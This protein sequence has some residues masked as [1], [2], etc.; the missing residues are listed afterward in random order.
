MDR[1]HER[2]EGERRKQDVLQT[3]AARRESIVNRARRKLLERLLASGK[4]T[5]DDVYRSMTLPAGIDPR[6]LGSVPGPVARAGIIRCIGYGKSDRRE[7]HASI[8]SVW[9]LLDE[10]AARDWLAR[11]PDQPDHGPDLAGSPVLR[12]I[13]PNKGTSS[14]AA[15]PSLF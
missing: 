3:L 7:R 13:Q 1:N 11:H 6:C 4:A 8:L 5:A 10:S 15:Q 2:K 14:A 9:A 12:P